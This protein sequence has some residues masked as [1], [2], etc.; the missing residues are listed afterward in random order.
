MH[1][2][3]VGNGDFYVAIKRRGI[4]RL[5]LHGGIIHHG[6]TSVLDDCQT[7]VK[8]SM[9]RVCRAADRGEYCQV[10]EATENDVNSC[11]GRCDDVFLYRRSN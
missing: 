5:P 10:A 9:P 6:M 11:G 1:A 7:S 3:T 2:F 4:Y 8:S